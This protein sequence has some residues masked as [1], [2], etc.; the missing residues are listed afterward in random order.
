MFIIVY[1]VVGVSCI[2]STLAYM[3]RIAAADCLIQA[4]ILRN[5]SGKLWRETQQQY[6][7]LPVSFEPI[8]A[9][10]LSSTSFQQSVGVETNAW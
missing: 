2:R 3:S 8:N 1:V 4:S 7:Y 6:Y 5:T 9:N 10:I